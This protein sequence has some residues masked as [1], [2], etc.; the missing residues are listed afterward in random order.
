MDAIFL[1]EGKAI[2]YACGGTAVD[3]GDVVVENELIGI[4]KSPIAANT[5]GTLAVSGVFR[6]KK[7]TGV[8][9]SKGN[10]VY[11]N[12][13]TGATKVTTDTL[14]GVAIKDAGAELYVDVLLFAGEN[15]I[16]TVVGT[17]A[18]DNI[19]RKAITKTANATLTATE[20]K[21]GVVLA[22]K[23][24]G[25]LTITLPAAAAGNAGTILTIVRVAHASAVTITDG[26]LTHNTADAI[27]DTVTVVSTGAAWYVASSTIS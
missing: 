9:Y 27:G 19:A 24:D 18:V 10:L 2:D 11:W 23:A 17:L 4:A 12:A 15:A 14:M 13:T 16:A 25:A 3:A 7:A 6:V 8:T 21:A 22:A 26:T 1:Q 20:I 5:T